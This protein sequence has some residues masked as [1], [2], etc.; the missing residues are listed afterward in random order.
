MRLES[1][2][3][4]FEGRFLSKEEQKTDICVSSKADGVRVELTVPIYGY[5]R[6][7]IAYASPTCVDHPYN[8]ISIFDCF[9]F[10]FFPD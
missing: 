6:L 1:N 10:V 7:A 9:D 8:I 4:S 5:E 2:Q 3:Q